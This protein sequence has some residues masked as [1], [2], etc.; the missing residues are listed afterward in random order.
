MAVVVRDVVDAQ[1][2]PDLGRQL[3]GVEQ[4]GEPI[5]RVQRT[6]RDRDDVGIRV[7]EST[8]F[9]ALVDTRRL[10]EGPLPV[11][12][13]QANDG[14]RSGTVVVEQRLVRRVVVDQVDLVAPG[15][16]EPVDELGERREPITT[17][18]EDWIRQDP[19][20]PGRK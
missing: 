5:E 10:P 16:L 15:A 6:V 20:F 4:L 3:V 1:A 12:L 17:V 14:V 19:P 7:D 13:V 2:E 18:D 11:V 8:P 9:G